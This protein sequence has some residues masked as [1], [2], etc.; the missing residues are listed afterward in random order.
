MPTFVTNDRH[1]PGLKTEAHFKHL[2][3]LTGGTD[4]TKR[5]R[6]TYALMSAAVKEQWMVGHCL[7]IL[8]GSLN[9]SRKHSG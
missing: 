1:E 8:L 9:V 5:C 7:E 2:H 3:S 6:R 4:S